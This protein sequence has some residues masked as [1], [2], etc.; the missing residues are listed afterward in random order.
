MT[1]P[2]IAN[3]SPNGLAPRRK[4]EALTLLMPLL[5]DRSQAANQFICELDTTFRAE[6]QRAGQRLG[7]DAAH[8]HLVEIGGEQLVLVNLLGA[9]LSFSLW[10]LST[11][12]LPFDIW[13]RE[14]LSSLTGALESDPFPDEWRS[15]PNAGYRL[16]AP[17]STGDWYSHL[18]G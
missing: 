9:N 5:P 14:R 10:R 2:N 13:L 8:W 15:E 11:S 1:T 18:R 17:G 6:M 12:E 16:A 7:V 3:G 4:V